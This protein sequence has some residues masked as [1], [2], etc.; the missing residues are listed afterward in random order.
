MSSKRRV[1]KKECGDK[2]KNE[3]FAEANA[4]AKKQSFKRNTRINAYKCKWCGKFHIGHTDYGTKMAIINH[5][6]MF[7]K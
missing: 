3:T 2:D 4:L 6:K 1:R 5:G 7:P